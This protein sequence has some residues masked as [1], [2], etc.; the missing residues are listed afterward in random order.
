M[1][2]FIESAEL[3]H[4]AAKNK[5]GDC[6]FSGFGIRQDRKLAVGCYIEGAELSNSDSMVNLGTIHLNGIPNLVEKSYNEAY[7]Y[8]LKAY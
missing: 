7:R 4:P 5:M 1:N 3:D 8:F 2:Y 6:Y